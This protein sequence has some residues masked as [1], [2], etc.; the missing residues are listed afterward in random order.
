MLIPDP[1]DEFDLTADES[2][3]DLLKPLNTDDVSLSVSDCH[4]GQ[5]RNKPISRPQ[6]HATTWPYTREV[7]S[8]IKMN[9]GG[10]I[11]TIAKENI[12]LDHTQCHEN[13]ESLL[14]TIL[15]L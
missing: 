10:I 8:E 5:Q 3:E 11:E 12:Q 4:S 6:E 1:I 7:V 13:A 14:S 2:E 9:P 15:P